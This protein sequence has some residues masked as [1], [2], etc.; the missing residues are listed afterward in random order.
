ML[1]LFSADLRKIRLL[2]QKPGAVHSKAITV[3]FWWAR[4]VESV[5]KFDIHCCKFGS[6][7]SIDLPRVVAKIVSIV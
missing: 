3:G 1:S 2:S 4:D 5:A 6:N 7:H